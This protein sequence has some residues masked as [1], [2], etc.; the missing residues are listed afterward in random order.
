MAPVCVCGCA[1]ITDDPLS[2]R[3]HIV[4]NQD[5]QNNHGACSVALEVACEA[6]YSPFCLWGTVAVTL[7]C[8]IPETYP[9]VEPRV[10][11]AAYSRLH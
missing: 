6:A 1:E 2:Y 3:V 7:K 10:S 8:M 4:P 11:I 9:D 5:G